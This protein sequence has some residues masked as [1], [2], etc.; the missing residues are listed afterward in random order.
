[1]EYKLHITGLCR[2]SQGKHNRSSSRIT[3]GKIISLI[4][5]YYHI[6]GEGDISGGS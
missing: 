2:L 1:M 4:Y 6:S 5:M 3:T